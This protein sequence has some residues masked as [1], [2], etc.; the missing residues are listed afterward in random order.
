MKYKASTS[1][2]PGPHGQTISSCEPGPHGKL[3]YPSQGLV[4][5]TDENRQIFDP[6]KIPRGRSKTNHQ[7][8]FLKSTNLQNNRRPQFHTEKLD[9]QILM[10][11]SPHQLAKTMSTSSEEFRKFVNRLLYEDTSKHKISTNHTE[12]Q[13]AASQILINKFCNFN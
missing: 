7:L 11:K 2:E 4:H 6:T 13:T 1:S 8:K 9:Q 5:Q 12:N 10:D 3:L